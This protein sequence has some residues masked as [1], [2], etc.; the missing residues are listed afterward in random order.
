MHWRL[1]LHPEVTLPELPP[2]PSTNQVAAA[3]KLL[4]W[5][6]IATPCPCV[7]A[8]A[9]EHA[10]TC[11]CPQFIGKSV[12]LHSAGVEGNLT[13]QQVSIRRPLH[14]RG[15]KTFF[16]RVIRK[17]LIERMWFQIGG[18]TSA[19][20]C[21]PSCRIVCSQLLQ[22]STTALGPASRICFFLTSPVLLG[23]TSCSY[24]ELQHLRFFRLMPGQGDTRNQGGGLC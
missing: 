20:S 10:P 14:P 17:T 16:T 23:V 19:T 2:T 11:P 18:R 6:F 4:L 15:V 13:P 24:A 8:L 1:C 9:R 5:A 3:K 7:I 22:R 12:T 21:G